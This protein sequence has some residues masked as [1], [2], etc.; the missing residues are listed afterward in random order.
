MIY[1]IVYFIF[2]ISL[3]LEIASCKIK[4]KE[5][6]ERHGLHSDKKPSE[7]AKEIGALSKKQKRAYKKLLRR[8]D[9]AIEKRNKEKLKNIVPK[10]KTKKVSGTTEKSDAPKT[11]EVIIK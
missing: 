8:T 2:I 5:Y 1:R 6:I 9:K 3:S 10:I 11:K 7:M 4:R